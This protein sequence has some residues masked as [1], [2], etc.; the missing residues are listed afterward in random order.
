MD[1]QEP[2]IEEQDEGGSDDGVKANIEFKAV[3]KFVIWNPLELEEPRPPVN[4]EVSVPAMIFRIR[5]V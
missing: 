3:F 4:C 2:Q 5:I 1:D